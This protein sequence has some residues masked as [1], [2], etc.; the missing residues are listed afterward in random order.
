MS[1]YYASVILFNFK[2]FVYGIS[3]LN[4]QHV[5]AH[6]GAVNLARLWLISI[7]QSVSQSVRQICIE[8]SMID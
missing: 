2:P 7:L 6:G 8:I 5:S 4:E 1:G 3:G